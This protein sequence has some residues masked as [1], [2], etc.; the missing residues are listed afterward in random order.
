MCGTRTAHPERPLRHAGDR[1][2]DEGT[3]LLQDVLTPLDYCPVLCL[4][5]ARCAGAMRWW[6][7][8]DRKARS[9]SV[10][11]IPGIRQYYLDRAFAR[12]IELL[13]G[14]PRAVLTI[15]PWSDVSVAIVDHM[16]KR[17]IA[18]AGIRTQTTL[19]LDEHLVINTDV[20]F[21]K[22]VWEKE[23]VFPCSFVGHGP[24]LVDGCLLQSARGVRS[25]TPSLPDD[26]VLLVGHRAPI[27]PGRD[28]L[29]G[30]LRLLEQV[31]EASGLPVVYRAHPANA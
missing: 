4:W 7:S 17:A 8:G 16:R 19:Q 14:R 1:V 31:A 15:A 25:R 26:F 13:H 21:C 6:F 11:A 24:A 23:F 2:D 22:G 9:L 28:G 30:R 12:R 18:T 3:L 20:L 27:Q 5:L 29:P 10:A